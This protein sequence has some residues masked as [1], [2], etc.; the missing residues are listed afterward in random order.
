MLAFCAPSTMTNHCGTC[1]HSWSSRAK[2]G[3]SKACPKCKSK[4]VRLG[5]T[6]TTGP[7]MSVAANAYPVAGYGQ[8][9]QPTPRRPSSG[10]LGIALAVIAGVGVLF[11]TVCGAIVG[12]AN[13]MATNTASS[14]IATTP[15]ATAATPTVDIAPP[16]A[17]TTTTTVG[18]PKQTQTTT[19]AAKPA[20]PSNTS[21]VTGCAAFGASTCGDGT[22]G[23]YGRG[24]CSHHGGIVR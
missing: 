3:A 14:P 23:C 12:S 19:P 10:G 20:P 24:C 21:T 17:K 6:T 15:T 5:V 8:A 13:K 4:D 7:Q 2:S 9:W 22:C 18:T 1:F 11:L 16:S